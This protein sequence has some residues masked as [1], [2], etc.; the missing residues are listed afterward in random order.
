MTKRKTKTEPNLF[1]PE[2]PD[3]WT[4][5]DANAADAEGWNIYEATGYGVLEIERNQCNDPPHEDAPTY[6]YDDDATEH[7]RI[8]AAH[9]SELHARALAIH[10]SYRETQLTVMVS[11]AGE[12]NDQSVMVAFFPEVDVGGDAPGDGRQCEAAKTISRD[13]AF[14]VLEQLKDALGNP[15]PVMGRLWWRADDLEELV[16]HVDRVAKAGGRILSID[17]GPT[18]ISYVFE[19]DKATASA[20]LGYAV[21]DEEWLIADHFVVECRGDDGKYVRATKRRF[22]DQESAQK[23]A[24]T[25]ARSRQAWVR[26]VYEAGPV[27]STGRGELIGAVVR[28]AQALLDAF[29]G[30][31][32]EWIRAEA[33]ALDDS[34]ARLLSPDGRTAAEAHPRKLRK[35]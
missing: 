34:I 8:R 6:E 12:E 25:I 11:T 9:G 35:I 20:K 33:A 32:P 28:T 1:A 2:Y 30:N 21:G 4:A 24:D 13:D 22:P 27:R 10:R 31:T 5:A 7:V 29:G 17:P 15:S 19:I 23:Y 3:Q 26:P 18:D 14:L 16:S